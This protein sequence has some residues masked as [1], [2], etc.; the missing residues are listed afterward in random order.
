MVTIGQPPYRVTKH[1]VM[2]LTKT[3]AEVAR[4]GSGKLYLP[5]CYPHLNWEMILAVD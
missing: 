4:S 5:E 2:Y 1:A 3:A